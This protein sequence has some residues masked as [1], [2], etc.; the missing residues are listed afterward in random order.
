MVSPRLALNICCTQKEVL[1]VMEPT[2]EFTP[3]RSG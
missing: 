1:P 2:V 3:N